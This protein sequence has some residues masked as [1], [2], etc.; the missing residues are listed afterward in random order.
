VLGVCLGA[1]MIAS[2]LGG[3]VYRN[4]EREVGWFG[5]KLTEAGAGSKLFGGMPREFVPCHWHG[6]TFDLPAGAVLAARSEGCRNQAFFVGERVVGLQFHLE[7]TGE[8]VELMLKHC[9]EDTKKAGRF[10]QGAVALRAGCAKYG[11]ESLRWM[12]ELMGRLFG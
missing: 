10:V 11:G 2:A 5:V 3:K 12:G 4:A 9:L 8:S 1:Q 6:E 7:Y